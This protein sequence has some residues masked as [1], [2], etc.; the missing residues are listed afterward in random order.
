VRR[1]LRTVRG[2]GLGFGALRYLG[3]PAVRERLSAPGPQVVFN[4]L[5]QWDARSAEPGAGFFREAHTSLGREHDPA[6]RSVHALEVI[7]AVRDGRLAFT[8]YYRPDLHDRRAV[9]SVAGDFTEALR[10]I[11]RNCREI[12]P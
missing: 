6:D 4:Y 8:W 1:Q 11:A 5:G 12:A 7:G 10:E 9:E 3:A 2:N